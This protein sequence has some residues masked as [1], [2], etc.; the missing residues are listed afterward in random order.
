MQ[1]DV[2]DNLDEHDQEMVS[3][4]DTTDQ[5]DKSTQETEDTPTEE[6]PAWLP[7]KFKTVE[8]FVKSYEALES[9]IGQ[10]KE[11]AEDP[12]KSPTTDDLKI[13][14]PED[15]NKAKEVVEE[16]GFNYDELATKYMTNGDL[17]EDDYERLSKAGISKDMVDAYVAGQEALADQYRQS[18]F[19]IVGGQEEYTKMIQWAG[20]NLSKGEIAAFDKIAERGSYEELQ[21]AVQGLNAR[22]RG[23]V[24]TKPKLLSGGTSNSSSPFRSTK[25]LTEAMRDPRYQ[26]DSGYR[27][28]VQERLRNSNIL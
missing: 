22:Y 5:G 26:T 27:S 13:D 15:T 2:Q 8:D 3:K 7:E 14:Q 1:T 9:K 19:A 11:K 6:R 23:A 25:E 17:D 20:K 4:F 21:M 16:A 28:S 12:K 10:P 24:G 18:T